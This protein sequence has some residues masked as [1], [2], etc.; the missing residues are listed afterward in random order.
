MSARHLRN[1]RSPIVL[2]TLAMTAMWACCAHAAATLGFVEN[3]P[4]AAGTGTWIN[5]TPA[6]NPGTGGVGGDGDGYL[7]IS[8]TVVTHFGKQ[9]SGPE[10]AGNWTALGITQVRVWLND[11]NAN[12]NL[13]MH[14]STGHGDPTT[15]P[16]NFWQ[17]NVGF[18]PPSNKWAEFVVDLTS[19]NWTPIT[20]T[21]TL[22]DA[23][24]RVDRV[25]LRNDR[26]PFIGT[27]DFTAGDLGIDHILLTN[28]IVG[29]GPNP[30]MVLQPVRLAPP[31]PNPSRG[32][33]ALALE[34]SD[35]S[36][37]HLQ[38]VDVTGRSVRSAELSAGVSGMRI[39]TWDGADDQGRRVAPGYYRVRAWSAAGGTSR[40]LIR[41]D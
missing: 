11:V 13:E 22:A 25:H 7:L 29:V 40:A 36:P 19:A 3:F 31:S 1:A 15:G 33:V 35:T 9:S 12:D 26:A 38:V 20:G 6:S 5:G 34:S 27:P 23:L 4:A 8:N 21:G 30:T 28:G 2:L 18:I 24:T 17:Y 16:T 37:V 41:V 32:S 14:F 10:W 39:W